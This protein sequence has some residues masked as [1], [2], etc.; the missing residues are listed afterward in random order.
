M[1]M[2]ELAERLKKTVHLARAYAHGTGTIFEEAMRDAE[3]DADR[4]L[5]EIASQEPT[6]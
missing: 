2:K 1:T 4:V 6:Q 3:R 5:A